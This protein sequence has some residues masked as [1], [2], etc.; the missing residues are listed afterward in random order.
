MIKTSE[1]QFKLF[2]KQCDKCK[3]LLGLQD[4]DITYTWAL[5]DKPFALAEAKVQYTSEDK[6]VRV[7][8]YKYMKG[9]K[10]M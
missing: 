6:Q 4:W 8:L 1:R 3:E 7:T 5:L 10:N 2:C 9:N